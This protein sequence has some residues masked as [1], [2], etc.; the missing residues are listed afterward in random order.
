MAEKKWYINKPPVSSIEKI[1]KCSQIDNK[2]VN[3]HLLHEKL[4]FGLNLREVS[5]VYYG[6]L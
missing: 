6:I 1:Q 5:E 3:W 4:L 2:I